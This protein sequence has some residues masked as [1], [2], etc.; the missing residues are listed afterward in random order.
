MPMSMPML[1]QSGGVFAMHITNLLR[2]SQISYTG[3][4]NS[5]P[6]P[7][8]PSGITSSILP[9]RPP[10]LLPFC[11]VKGVFAQLFIDGV[12]CLAH[13]GAKLASV[14]H[15]RRVF[16]HPALKVFCAD[17][18]WIQLAECGEER[19]GLSLQLRRRLRRVSG[20]NGVEECP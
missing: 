14:A 20:R 16:A 5:L 4:S 12:V 18:T 19:S 9:T 3:T 17:P 1:L 6:W 15:S 11:A 10:S 2:S 8:L 7:E 13:P